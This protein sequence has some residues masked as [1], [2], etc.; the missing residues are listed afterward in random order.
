MK[1]DIED[2]L[3][4]LQ[5]TKIDSQP[6]D[7]DLNKLE[8]KLSELAASFPIMNGGGSHGHVGMIMD[9]ANY[10]TFSTGGVPFITPTNP[11][12]YPMVVDLDAVVHE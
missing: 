12:P 2:N 3:K 4:T 1:Q 8:S 10:C 7:K 9:D 5:I 6:T 11:G